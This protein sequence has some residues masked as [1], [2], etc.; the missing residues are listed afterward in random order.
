MNAIRKELRTLAELEAAADTVIELAQS[1][2]RIFSSQLSVAYNSPDRTEKLRQFLLASPRNR[3]HIT[4]HDAA[5]VQSSCPRM[6]VLLRTFSHNMAIRETGAEAKGAHDEIILA[7]DA[8]Y[9]HRIHFARARGEMVLRD[10]DATQEL[11]QRF[12][13]IWLASS[14]SIAAT[15]LGL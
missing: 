10:A 15:T 3:L 7:D 8:H 6:I 1:S 4:L 2:L 11:K 14:P 13:E 12:E 9:V 5:S